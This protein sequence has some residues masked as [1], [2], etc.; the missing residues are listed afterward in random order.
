MGSWA[1]HV[2]SWTNQE[3]LPIIVVRYEDLVKSPHKYFF[4]I[5]E[6]LKAKLK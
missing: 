4:Q 5:A 1:F 3:K 2:K 6:F